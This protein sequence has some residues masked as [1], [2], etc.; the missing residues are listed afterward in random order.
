MLD[1][2]ALERIAREGAAAALE[3]FGRVR[4]E[5]KED[6]SII[7]EADRVSQRVI[8]ARFRELEPDPR[9]L[10]FRGEESLGEVN[11]ALTDPMAAD[12][13]V[14]VDP[15][16]GTTAFSRGLPL[17]GVSIGLFVG[18]TLSA[19][20]VYMPLM[21]GREG[22][23][24]RGERGGP[25]LLNGLPIRVVPHDAWQRTSQIAVPSGALREGYLRNYPGK[26]RS[27]GSVAHHVALVAAGR[28]DGA[29]LGRPRAW[30]IAG[31]A[32]ILEGAGGVI[33]DT[34]G[35][36]VDWPRL[37]RG[38]RPERPLL[39]GTAE[40]VASLAAFLTD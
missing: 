31:G 25:S 37:L 19:G 11:G 22:W 34:A 6:G 20:V 21:G 39:A 40:A 9:R 8:L 5:H 30:D 2:A 24:Y 13:V 35:A 4:P 26:A 12:S 16:D 15:V 29:L 17:W 36:P 10:F 33:R 3:L 32:A 27:L 14:A 23:L 7:T 38:N 1:T 18:G 28:L